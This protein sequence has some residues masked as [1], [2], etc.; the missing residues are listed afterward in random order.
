ME[1]EFI[2]WLTDEMEERGWNN[3][4]LARRA[5]LVPS[6]VSQVVSGTRSPGFEFCKKTAKALGLPPETVLREA[7]LLPRL[8]SP[9]HGSMTLQE[10][11]DIIKNLPPE[12]QSDLLS[13]ALAWYREHNG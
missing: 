12:R 7:G 9:D 10:L 8:S 3:S 5:G 6:A 11:V 13:I 4:E 2:T 1:K